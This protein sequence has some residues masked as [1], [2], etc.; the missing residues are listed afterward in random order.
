LQT[1]LIERPPNFGYIVKVFPKAAEPGVIF[2]FGEYIYNPSG[3]TIPPALLAHEAVHGERQLWPSMIS[4]E[5]WW[6]KYLE[7]A[8]FRYN[9]ELPAHAAEFHAQLPADRNDRAKLLM[10]TAR[11]LV[12]PLYAYGTRYTFNNAIRDLQS[13]VEGKRRLA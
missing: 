13:A 5:R 11:R 4:V 1:V 7:D 9:E 2:A 10:S 8:E 6:E 12:A 3:F